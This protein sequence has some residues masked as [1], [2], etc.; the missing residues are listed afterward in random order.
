[1]ACY[2]HNNREEVAKCIDCGKYLCSECASHINP[3][4]CSSCAKQYAKKA[5]TELYQSV[6]IAIALL[7]VGIIFSIWIGNPTGMLF[8]G[9]PF[10]WRILNM[11]TPRFFIWMPIMGWVIYFLIK[12]LLSYIIGFIALPIYVFRQVKNIN[13]A[14]KASKLVDAWGKM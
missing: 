2:Y 8:I 10:G 12:F 11:L 1:M 13:N 14:V 9:I 4:T 3:P 5:Q 6:I 7:I